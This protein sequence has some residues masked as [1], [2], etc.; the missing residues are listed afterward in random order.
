MTHEFLDSESNYQ[1]L[2][3][4]MINDQFIYYRQLTIQNTKHKPSKQQEQFLQCR[5]LPAR[6]TKLH[7]IAE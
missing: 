4:Y 5:E 6:E 7:N 3:G 1:Y 2:T